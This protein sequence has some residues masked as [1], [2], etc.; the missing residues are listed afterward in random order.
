MFDKIGDTFMG[1]TVTRVRTSKELRGRLVEL[2][3]DKTATE[4]C[5]LDNG[6]L[7]KT[8]SIAFKTVPSD[9]TGVFHILEHS[10]LC[11]SEKFPVREPFVELIKSSLNTFLN[12]M[13]FPDKTMYP[14][15]SR[16]NRDFLNLTEVYLDAVLAPRLLRD[17]NIFY[18]EGGHTEEAE[19]GTLSFKGVVFNEMK[20]AMSSRDD[21]L[22]EAMGS[23]L[24]P[25]SCYG[26][27]SGGDPTAIPDLTYERFVDT[28]KRFYHPSNAR[29]YVDGD[30]P[31][32]ETFRLI[33]SYL[34][35]YERSTALPEIAPQQPKAANAMVEFAQDPKE[36][37][38]NKSVL[39]LGKIVGTWEDRVTV[40]A[41]NVLNEAIAGSNEA[42][43]KRAILSR[44]LAEEVEYS[45]NSYTAQPSFT[46]KL[47]NI[48]DGSADEVKAFIRATVEKMLEEGLDREAIEA[49][50]NRYAYRVKD[51]AEPQGLERAIDM[52]N[53]WLYGGDPMTCLV[54]DERIEA[55]RGMLNGDGYERLLRR[56]YLDDSAEVTVLACPSRTYAQ[57]LEEAESKRLA[58]IA[59]GRSEE[60]RAA[61][62]SL[63]EKL[64]AWQSTP[65][66]PEQLATMP[67]LP[68]SEV[69]ED[70]DFVETAKSVIDGVP[71][72]YHPVAANG[73]V[74]MNLYFDVADIPLEKMAELKL[75]TSV[76]GSMETQKRSALELEKLQKNTVGLLNV[77]LTDFSPEAEPDA[78]RPV[79]MVS[80]SFLRENRDKAMELVREVLFGTRLNAERIREQLV[81]MLESAKESL[82]TSGNR[83]GTKRVA[84]HYSSSGVL[85]EMTE[86]YSFVRYLKNTAVGAFDSF[87]DAL[88]ELYEGLKTDT[89]VRA[90]MTVGVTS[91]EPTDV[92]GLIALFP[93]GSATVTSATY[94]LELP[95]REGFCTTGRVGFAVQGSNLSALGLPN[96]GSIRVAAHAASYGYLW[97]KVRVQ[98][99]AYGTGFRA[100]MRGRLST[101]SYRDPTPAKSLQA[102]AGISAYLKDLANGDEPLE[103]FIIATVGETEPLL[104]PFMKGIFADSQ[105]FSGLTK[106]D[107][108][109]E[110]RQIL[111]T[112]KEKLL[113]TCEVFDRFSAE[114]AVCV[115]GYE[116]QLKE[117]GELA[118]IEL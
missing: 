40:A 106:E 86:G 96:D 12:A 72:L 63:N 26:F 76:F 32:E 95:H 83:Y 58:A 57:E 19:D 88:I 93:E 69:G 89:F 104:S 55:L 11:G 67:Q 39:C 7:N 43:L 94:R 3:Y 115:T 85:G 110:R 31:A 17:A 16:N 47:I 99:G 82:P 80:C 21:L 45:V 77:A 68:L 18:Q 51:I 20:G 22:E 90:R 6:E 113:L 37:M 13:T 105:Y 35:R 59:D 109:R 48:K 2:V 73:I 5:W 81:Q 10:V 24:F 62:R 25:D 60:E 50:V 54:A 27:N 15:C 14:V 114:G 61:N 30:I 97:N 23:H 98:G 65:D 117:C 33:A 111:A 1:F 91:D 49:A 78:C 38:E 102:N 42:P 53:T 74:H 112:D 75:L 108:L 118:R 56:L 79:V 103:K 64:V 4:I 29:I 46:F 70:I 66:T 36:P 101:W 8:F 92:A 100:S 9:S 116:E 87:Y 41:M 84:A 44:G 28:Y 71:V 34:C 107:F 52:L